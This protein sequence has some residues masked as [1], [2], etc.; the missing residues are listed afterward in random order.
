MKRWICHLGELPPV[1]EQ[2]P[3]LKLYTT[4]YEWMET[5]YSFG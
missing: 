3:G 1:L 2:G 4:K 5:D